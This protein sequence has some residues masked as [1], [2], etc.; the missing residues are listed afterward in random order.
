MDLSF[1]PK[2][3]YEGRRNIRK[4]SKEPWGFEKGSL[5]FYFHSVDPL[6]SWPWHPFSVV[7][8][9]VKSEGESLGIPLDRGI[10]M[11][12]QGM[13]SGTWGDFLGLLA[14]HCRSHIIPQVFCFLLRK[15][16]AGK[17][18]HQEEHS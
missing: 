10:L 5:T 17:V 16:L 1:Y 7:T 14:G 2:S 13:A 11:A 9:V 8:W 3:S 12:S 18:L 15:L 6:E 4:D